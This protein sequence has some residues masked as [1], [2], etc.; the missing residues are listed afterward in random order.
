MN[1]QATL[2]ILFLFLGLSYGDVFRIPLKY[3]PAPLG[4]RGRAAERLL[5]KYLLAGGDTNGTVIFKDYQDA[6]YYGPVDIGTPPQRFDVVYDTG[7]S[8]LWVPSKKCPIT[9]IACDVHSKYDSTK[10]STYAANATKFA[11]QYGTGSVSGF[12]SQDTVNVGGVKIAKQQF[13]EATS[14]PGLTFAVAKFDG[15]LGL[16]FQSISEGGVVPPWYNMLDQKL[17]TKPVFSTWLNKDPSGITGGELILG[18][19]DGKRYEG[20]ISYFPLSSETYWAFKFADITVDGVSL[21]LCPGG[22]CQGIADTGTSL[23][24]GPTA[25]VA[26]LNKKLGALT[27]INGEAII[28]C[29]NIPKMPSVTI[30]IGAKSFVLTPKDYVLEVTSGTSTQ[31]ISGFVG[32]DIPSPPGPLWILGDVFIS[33]YYTVFDFGLKQVGFAKAIQG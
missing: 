27:I 1:I 33:T 18:G 14:L 31:C 28:N 25:Q 13:G 30:V 11:I 3:S 22:S 7:S 24:A 26:A 23:I 21:N 6:Q 17:I 20:S 9:V 4:A 10:S 16:A 29:A 12:I 19:I 32:I 2:S 8:N 5:A 15:I